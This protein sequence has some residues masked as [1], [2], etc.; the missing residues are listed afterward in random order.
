MNEF[1]VFRREKF[2]FLYEKKSLTVFLSL[3]LVS[4]LS[5]LLSLSIGQ[6]NYS[7]VDV[8]KSLIGIGDPTKDFIIKSLRLPRTLVAF[9]VGSSLALSGA[10]LQGMVKNPLASPD[11]IGIT[12]GG[13]VGALVFLTLFT[14]PFN[15]S[16]TVSIFYMPIFTFSGAFLASILIYFTSFKN[17]VTP[18]R[19]ILVGIA[20]SGAA[21]ALTSILILN[22]PLVFIAESNI[23]LTGS[24]YGTNW[25]HFTLLLIWFVVFSLISILFIRDLNIQNLDDSLAIGLGSPIE[26]KRFILL[27]LS[28]TLAC[29]AVAVGGGIG[30]VGLVAPHICRKLTNSSFENILPQS[31]LVGGI[32]VVLSDLAARTLFAPLDIPVGVFT[33]GVGAPFFIYL[34]WSKRK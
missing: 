15:N 25:D 28:T 8:A 27:L 5:I 34:L 12:S 4:I 21:K 16:L 9:L 26:K 29:G 19:L 33:A 18:Y 1:L 3:M 6:T 14:N 31:V 23:W 7:I 30:F 11:L 20:V 22:G 10:I 13:S 2:S 24:V 17:G 32:I